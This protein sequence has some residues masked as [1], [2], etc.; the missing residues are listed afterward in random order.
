MEPEG[1]LPSSHKAPPDRILS[2]PNPIR[3]IVSFRRSIPTL[4]RLLAFKVPN[5]MSFSYL[6]RAK[7]SVQ[8]RGALK[9][10]VTNYFFT[11]TGC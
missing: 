6:G 3:P 7:E 9:H 5:L 4:Q 8:A 10:F 1:S 2:Q 11:V